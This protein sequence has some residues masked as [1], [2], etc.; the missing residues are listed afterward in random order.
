MLQ[1]QHSKAGFSLIELLAVIVILGILAAFLVP[2][3]AGMGESTRASLTRAQL[4]VLESAIKEYEHEVGD[5]PPSAWRDEWGG[6]PNGVNI[7]AETLFVTLWSESWGGTSLK[8]DE[9]VNTDGDQARKPLTTLGSRDLFELSD[10]WDNPIA[11]FHRRDYDRGDLYLT[12]DPETGDEYEETVKARMSSKT[13][14]PHNPRTFQL[15]SAGPN[16]QFG[17]DDD[18]TNFKTD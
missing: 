10:A 9:L 5:F 8:E 7:G 15:I 1:R 6:Q 16:G 4:T 18:I 3:L 14:S 12:L 2:R 17:D 11:Y 13:K